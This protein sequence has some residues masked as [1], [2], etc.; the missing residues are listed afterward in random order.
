[1]FQYSLTKPLRAISAN[2]DY[3]ANKERNPDGQKE[4]TGSSRRPLTDIN[5]LAVRKCDR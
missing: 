3:V 4:K 5:A 2:K 1:M